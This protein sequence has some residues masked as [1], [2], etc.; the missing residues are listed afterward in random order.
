MQDILDGDPATYRLA[1]KDAIDACR[2][3]WFASM[4]DPSKSPL[5][6]HRVDAD[7]GREYVKVDRGLSGHRWV[8]I[9]GDWPDRDH[10]SVK[11]WKVVYTPAA[12]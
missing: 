11:G 8:C 10:D 1:V 4:D 12:K 5:G 6:E 3:A 7:S 2:A 9:S